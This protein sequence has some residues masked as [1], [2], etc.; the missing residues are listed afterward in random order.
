MAANEM[1]HSCRL[2]INNSR[3]KWR[4]KFKFGTEVVHRELNVLCIYKVK[5]SKVRS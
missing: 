1:C 4:A 3:P 5:R 2:V